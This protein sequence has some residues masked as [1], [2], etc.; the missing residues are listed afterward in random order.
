MRR[1]LPLTLLTLLL[2]LCSCGGGG[3]SGSPQP[4]PNGT[5]R[6]DLHS[7]CEGDFECYGA[8]HLTHIDAAVNQPRVSW[9]EPER[10]RKALIRKRQDPSPLRKHPIGVEEP[11]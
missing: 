11:I 9:K 10:L 6:R 3:S 8:E 4:N 7:E 5:P 2:F 1:Y